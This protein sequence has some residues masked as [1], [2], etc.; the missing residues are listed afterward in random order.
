MAR[1]IRVVQTLRKLAAECVLPGNDNPVMRALKRLPPA[2]TRRVFEDP[3]PPRIEVYQGLRH[4]CGHLGDV[5]EEFNLTG[6]VR[7]AFPLQ[8]L[9]C[10]VNGGAARPLR[11]ERFRRIVEYGD[12]NADIPIAIL[13]PGE[14]SVE[15][16]AT[17]IRGAAASVEATLI[18]SRSGSYPLPATI[19]WSAVT[20]MDD[21]GE[22]TD[23]KWTISPEGLRTRQVGYDRLFLIGNKT[24][25]DYEATAVVTIHGMSARNGPQSGSVKHVGFCLRWAGHSS[26]DN[27]V[28][29]QPRSGLHPRGGIVWLTVAG[30]R[31]PPVRQFYPGDSE[32]FRTF[33][34]FAVRF[35]EP[36]RMKGSCETLEPGR[37]ATASKSGAWTRPNR[38]TGISRLYNTARRRCAR[39][40]WRWWRTNSMLRSATLTCGNCRI[41]QARTGGSGNSP[42]ANHENR[43]IEPVAH[44]VDGVAE[45]QI[46]DAAVAVRAH[47]Q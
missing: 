46:L 37:H 6:H 22:C 5:Q 10:R 41:R 3:A 18:R 21:V 47:D 4:R 16:T 30:G 43:N 25:T 26:G 23:G 11:F 27:R 19:R 17:D 36:F 32:I 28:D 42:V 35:G 8:E 2:I 45:D 1:N 39:G 29:D 31:L 38:P 40:R 44:G 33:D 7:A 9:T 24:W 34:P 14:N 15:L 13:K 12:F 20:D